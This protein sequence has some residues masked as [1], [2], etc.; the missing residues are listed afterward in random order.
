VW[1]Q[2]EPPKAP[3]CL[4]AAAKRL[5]REIVQ[6]RPADFFRPGSLD[7]LAT[8]CTVSVALP[9][10]WKQERTC[11]DD[12]AAHTRIVRRICALAAL[13]AR[14]CGDLRLTPRAAIERHSAMRD[15]KGLPPAPLLG[16]KAMRPS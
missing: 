3:G 1:R 16:G 12:P 4:T 13:Q 15:A 7:T 10:L 5:W 2:V 6:D 9:F 14:L 8:F 11:R